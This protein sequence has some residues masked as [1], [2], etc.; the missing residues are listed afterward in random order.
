MKDLKEF[1]LNLG[2]NTTEPYTTIGVSVDYSEFVNVNVSA[3][4]N[5]IPVKPSK[6]GD[7]SVV[8]INVE[9]WQNNHINLESISLNP[10]STYP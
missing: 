1:T 4:V 2:K 8:R 7:N 5:T 9:G 10:V 3:G 6:K